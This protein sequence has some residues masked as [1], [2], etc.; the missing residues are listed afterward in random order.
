MAGIRAVAPTA[1]PP[2][3]TG[4]A[5]GVASATIGATA[6]AAN[7]APAYFS[8]VIRFDP[9]TGVAVTEIRSS[10]TGQI[11]DQYP[12]VQAVAQYARQDQLAA[13]AALRGGTAPTAAAT[14]PG[15]TTP[16]Q[17]RLA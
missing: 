8:P 10:T 11:E 5:A 9:G 16:S 15:T 17:S 3:A 6:P 13:E 7:P 2:T 14:A 12:S 1:P 4:V